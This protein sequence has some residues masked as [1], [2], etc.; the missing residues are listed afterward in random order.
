MNQKEKKLIKQKSKIIIIFL[1]FSIFLTIKPNSL[2]LSD[3]VNNHTHIKTDLISHEPIEIWNDS[4]FGSSG[5]NFP[6]TGLVD[7]PYIIEN[8]NI[9][10]GED[11]FNYGIR[12]MLTTKY[13]VIKNC[14]V[15]GRMYAIYTG[16]T[17]DNTSRIE[18]NECAA[19]IAGGIVGSNGV[20]VEENTILGKKYGYGIICSNGYIKG[21]NVENCSTGIACGSNVIAEENNITECG[22]GISVAGYNQTVKLNVAM[23]NICGLNLRG[24]INSTIINNTFDRNHYS[25]DSW[26][27]DENVNISNNIFKDKK[28]RSRLMYNQFVVFENNLFENVELSL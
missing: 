22:A 27:W 13:F 5:Y 18:N 4:E 23:D 2:V 15:E 26:D 1:L 7:D 14:Y 24:A 8:Y 16:S 21:N 25:L 9:S 28:E 12:I 19:G 17:A 11:D 6:G 20:V 3:Q 10:L